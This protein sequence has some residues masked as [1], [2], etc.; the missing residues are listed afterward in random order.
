MRAI[1]AKDLFPYWGGLIGADE[2]PDDDLEISFNGA[3][4]V[5][6][7]FHLTDGCSKSLL[8]DLVHFKE[9]AEAWSGF[10]RFFHAP[11]S[12]R[13][14]RSQ[15]AA[16][17]DDGLPLSEHGIRSSKERR[18]RERVKNKVVAGS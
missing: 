9:V 3:L 16:A 2:E 17:R 4:R 18:Y 6:G 15:F 12:R 7:M 8:G 10:I 14:Y 1:S 13:R 5:P 11:A